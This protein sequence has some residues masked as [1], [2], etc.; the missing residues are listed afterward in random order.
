MLKVGLA[1]HGKQLSIAYTNKKPEPEYLE[2]MNL[3]EDVEYPISYIDVTDE[4][5]VM[6]NGYYYPQQNWLSQGYWS[7]KNVGDQLPFDYWPDE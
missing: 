4:I 1:C 3:P 2:K 7:W 6:A 5:S